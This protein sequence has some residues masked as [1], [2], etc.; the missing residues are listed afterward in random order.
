MKSPIVDDDALPESTAQMLPQRAGD[1]VGADIRR[2][3]SRGK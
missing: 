1:D 2:I 3:L